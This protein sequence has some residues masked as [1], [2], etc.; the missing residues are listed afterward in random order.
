MNYPTL[1]Q[2]SSDFS[3]EIRERGRAYHREGAVWVAEES[4]S[5]ILAVVQGGSRRHT[6]EILFQGSRATLSCSCPVFYDQEKPCKHL[7][8]VLLEL[9][10]RGHLGNRETKKTTLAATPPVNK[11]TPVSKR[12]Q[13]SPSW[14]V[15]LDEI[16]QKQEAEPKSHSAAWPS[17][18]E[19]LYIL[20]KE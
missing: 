9:D 4:P 14:K 8:A 13:P 10:K 3:H 11:P 15:A 19:I 17:G 5:R 2:L 7:W 1:E 16:R 12:R 6:V 18:R 20:S